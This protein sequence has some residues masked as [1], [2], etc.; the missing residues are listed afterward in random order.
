MENPETLSGKRGGR[1]LKRMVRPQ[2]RD[3]EA[4]SNDISEGLPVTKGELLR[5]VKWERKHSANLQNKVTGLRD[6][7]VRLGLTLAADDTRNPRLSEC[8]F[9]ISNALKRPNDPHEP[10][11]T[12]DSRKP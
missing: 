9:I 8:L 1:S 6:A 4:I 10:Q 12:C 2:R 11:P 7:M 5:V 3:C